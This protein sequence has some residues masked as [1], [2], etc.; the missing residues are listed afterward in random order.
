MENQNKSVVYIYSSWVVLT[1]NI[2]FPIYLIYFGFYV[3][4]HIPMYIFLIL[5]IFFSYVH[6][7]YVKIFFHSIYI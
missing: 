5:C 1:L 4:L 3:Y 2:I 7:I 6:V